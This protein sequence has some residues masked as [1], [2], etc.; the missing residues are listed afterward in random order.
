MSNYRKA[1]AE[2][3]F[4]SVTKTYEICVSHSF[5][6]NQ[7]RSREFLKIWKKARFETEAQLK[8]ARNLPILFLNCRI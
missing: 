4:A 8:V 1:I 7:T 5:H 2:L 3:F 6:D